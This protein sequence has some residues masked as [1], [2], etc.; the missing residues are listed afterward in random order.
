MPEPTNKPVV[1]ITPKP[2]TP[3]FNQKAWD[4]KLAKLRAC[5]EEQIGKPNHNPHLFFAAKV[6]PLLARYAKGER[7]VE[8]LNALLAFPDS[9]PDLGLKGKE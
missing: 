4:D 8:L 6:N 3:S 1:T 2:V 5:K 9:I 7:S